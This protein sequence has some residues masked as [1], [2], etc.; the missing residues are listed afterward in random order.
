MGSGRKRGV[1]LAA[2]DG[3][4]REEVHGR[5]GGTGV[6]VAQMDSGSATDGS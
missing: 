2:V 3:I 6:A 4:R 1:V 5:P